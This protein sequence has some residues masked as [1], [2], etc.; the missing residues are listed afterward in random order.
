MIEG[1]SKKETVKN[2]GKTTDLSKKIKLIDFRVCSDMD[3]E[4]FIKDIDSLS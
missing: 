1:N 3:V 4:R 2:S